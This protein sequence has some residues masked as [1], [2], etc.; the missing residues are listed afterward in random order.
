MPRN[1]M[2]VD[3]V[4]T[5]PELV[6]DLLLG[7][8]PEWASDPIQIMQPE[9]TDN[10]MYRLGN[11]KLIRLPRTK[12]SSLN[13][14]KEMTWLPKLEPSLPIPIPKIIGTGFPDKDYPFH[15]L[16]CEWLDGLNPNQ[17]GMLDEHMA[18]KDL[19]AFVKAMQH[20]NPVNGPSCRRGKPLN[21][22]DEEVKKSIPLLKELYDEKLI[23]ELWEFTS[24][25]PLWEHDPVWIHG[26]LHSGNLLAKEKKIVGVVDWGLAG[27]G[28][29]AC[30]MMVAWTLLGQEG[31]KIFRSIV[32]PDDDTWHRG[33]GWALFLGIVGYPYYRITNPIFASIAKRALDQVTTNHEGI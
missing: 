12:G 14:E 15:W 5:S 11:N 6:K 16:I 29:P 22:C 18:A 24:N 32:Q 31:R 17:E 28:D 23:S 26:D 27:V 3:E 4:D 8:F 21:T 10:A 1:K 7:Q 9:G 20:I 30:D 19:G 13:I 25:V 2:H 33:R